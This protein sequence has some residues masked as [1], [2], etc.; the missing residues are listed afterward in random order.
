MSSNKRLQIDQKPNKL[1]QRNRIGINT[2]E[3]SQ[4]LYVMKHTLKIFTFAILP[5]MSIG[6]SDMFEWDEG[7][8][9][10]TG[11]F[12]T[13][14]YSI[15]EIETI[16]NYLHSPSSEMLTVGN[17]WKIEQIDTATT[18]P[19]DKYYNK[20][21]TTLESMRIPEGEFWDSLLVSR[22]R[23]LFEVSQ[24]NRL[25]IL[26]LH[27][28]QVLNDYYQ[29][30]CA[31]EIIALTADS[32]T[33]LLEWRKLIDR[34]KLNN[35]YPENLERKYQMQLASLDRL[36]YARLDIM[37]YG[38]GNCM[39]QFIYYH[40]DYIRIEEEFQKLFLSV[41]RDDYED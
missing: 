10:Y 11:K 21:L 4:L 13:T 35:G 30:E 32:T 41:E 9:Y 14:E 2:I 28:P 29:E 8:T 22:K 34:Q 17:I 7:L 19:I 24:D 3:F 12:D 6:Q 5:F 36:K 26:A 31:D 16:Y 27:D 33:L 40:Q 25:F 37:K 18:S 20:T 15:E 38:W 39:N 1:V 23:E